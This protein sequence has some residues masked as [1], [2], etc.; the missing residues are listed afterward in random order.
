MKLIIGLG[1][2]GIRYRW[3]RH[4]LGFLV[5]EEF[6][7]Q[8]EIVWKKQRIFSAYIGQEQIEQEKIIL[9]KPLTYVNCSGEAVKK[10]VA[11]YDIDNKD[12]LVICDD[13]NLPLGKIRIR[14]K[15]SDGGHNGLKSIIDCLGTR[16]FSR[17]RIGI[18]K[19]QSARLSATDYVLSRFNREERKAIKEI[20]ARSVQ[21]IEVIIKEGIEKAMN[22]YN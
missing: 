21:T 13:L 6:A 8:K 10:V 5:I 4:N 2:P 12:I 19:P 20:I 11:K 18:D 14:A 22:G 16:E 3:T 7:K 17:L 15:G 9:C 1:N